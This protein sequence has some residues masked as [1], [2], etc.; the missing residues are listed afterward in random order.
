MVA[1]SLQDL[2]SKWESEKTKRTPKEVVS[3]LIMAGYAPFRRVSQDAGVVVWV[4]K[5]YAQS[6]HVYPAERY[7]SYD[8]AVSGGV[9]VGKLVDDSGVH[10]DPYATVMK[11]ADFY[12]APIEDFVSVSLS[13]DLEQAAKNFAV[14]V[15]NS[16]VCDE[17]GCKERTFLRGL[18]GMVKR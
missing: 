6:Q 10:Y 2:Q 5:M 4:K 8:G 17:K 18:G 15:D 11:L 16:V 12:G 13:K 1:N 9:R 3:F 14:L 7:R